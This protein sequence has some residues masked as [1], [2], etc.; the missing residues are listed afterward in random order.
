MTRV[1]KR[2]EIYA[3]AAYDQGKHLDHG[4]WKL[5]R[6]ITFS[7]IDAVGD[8][9]GFVIFFELSSR[10]CDWDA[11]DYGQRTLYWNIIRSTRHVAVLCK[12]H[13]PVD[14]DIR[15]WCDIDEA[16]L[17]WSHKGEDKRTQLSFSEFYE[18]VARWFYDVPAA[19]VSWATGTQRPLEYAHM[20][21][22][23]SSPFGQPQPQLDG[24]VEQLF[25]EW[26]GLHG[27]AEII[28]KLPA[29]DRFRLWAIETSRCRPSE[30]KLGS[31]WPPEVIDRS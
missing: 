31:P 26:H 16:C 24:P 10:T 12:H 3:R 2:G 27:N 1:A 21:V 14:R 11:L 19:A 6:N 7:D 25:V 23:G 8:N 13:V 9:N 15:T 28:D 20:A 17:R 29:L 4:G 22:E 30:L 5:P 18:F